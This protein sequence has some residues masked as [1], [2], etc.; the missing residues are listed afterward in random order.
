MAHTHTHTQVIVHSQLLHVNQERIA[1]L[2]WSVTKYELITKRTKCGCV[3]KCCKELL[4]IF[5][6][7]K[8]IVEKKIQSK[9]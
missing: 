5:I 7:H 2:G 1:V 8:M 6:H 9:K 3:C 4:D